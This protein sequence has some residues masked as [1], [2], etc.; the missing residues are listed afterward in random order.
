MSVKPSIVVA[1]KGT[2]QVPTVTSWPWPTFNGT[3]RIVVK[4][5]SLRQWYLWVSNLT[6]PLSLSYSSSKHCDM[7][8]FT[9]ITCFILRLMHL[10]MLCDIWLENV[11]NL[12]QYILRYT[13][14]NSTSLCNVTFHWLTSGF[15]QLASGFMQLAAAGRRR[16]IP[17]FHCLFE[18]KMLQVH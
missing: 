9:Y 6:L 2:L 12:W 17:N 14:A 11:I 4:C 18:G 1:L 3:N 13:V 10:Q 16:N 5:V 15:M 8:T 7:V